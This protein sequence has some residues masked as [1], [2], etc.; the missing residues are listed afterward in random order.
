LHVGVIRLEPEQSEQRSPRRRDAD[1]KPHRCLPSTS[2]H[3]RVC[4]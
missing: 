3:P 1:R 4:E 2:A